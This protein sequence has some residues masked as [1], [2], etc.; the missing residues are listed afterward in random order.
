MLV[1]GTH[2]RL[3]ESSVGCKTVLLINLSFSNRVAGI[4]SA[5]VSTR[6]TRGGFYISLF[7]RVVFIAFLLAF[8]SRRVILGSC[9]ACIIIYQP[10]CW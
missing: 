10:F 3:N 6:E 1:R 4:L 5:R 7:L 8:Y 2:G 9:T